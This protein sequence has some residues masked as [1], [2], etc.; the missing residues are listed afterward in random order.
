L[1]GHIRKRGKKWYIK[2]ELDRDPVTKKRRQKWYSG[3][4]T[5]KAAEAELAKLLHQMQTGT[6][7]EPSHLTVA[8]YLLKW[9]S[10][11]AK[12]NVAG[13]TFE[14]Y[15]QIVKNNLIPALGSIPLPKLQPLQIQNT[16]S[17]QLK[18][19]R[20]KG[21]GGLSAQTVLHHHRVLRK[22]LTQAVRW[23]LL[24][25]NPADRVEPPRVRQ[26]EIQPIDE[27][28]AAWLIEVS[29]GT[30]LYIPI[31]LAL[32]TGMRRGEILALRWQDVSLE[33][34][35]VSVCR[36]LEYTKANG[37]VFKEP[38]SRRGRRKLSLSPTVV[39][40]LVA[41]RAK[42]EEY[43][44]QLG[45]SYQDNG[46]V[47]CVEDGSVW[48]PP[49]FDSSYRQLL[50]RRK[51][52]GPTFHALRHSH[53]SHLLRSG[54]DAK[55]IS[56]RLGHSKVSFTLDQYVHLLPGMQ[57]EAAS[58]IETAM[59]AAREKILPKHVS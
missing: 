7:V 43:R 28:R 23:N 27:M 5:R 58:K 15:E 32:Y 26:K 51:L 40:A 54:V 13:K 30:R 12:P 11:Y 48:K 41:H 45:N 55:V 24:V 10:D 18:H 42:Q 50:K 46:L 59:N 2:L 1:Q 38:K 47:V 25:A 20:K 36:A 57:E 14:R 53:A 44:R 22:A 6:F 9:L 52:T 17:E 3:F 37:L 56:E 4:K 39:Q 19:G 8:E 16:Y 49:A 35:Y 21:E 34:G 31:L 33:T 29:Q